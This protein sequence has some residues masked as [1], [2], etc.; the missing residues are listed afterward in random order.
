MPFSLRGLK[1]EQ[2]VLLTHG[3]SVDQVAKEFKIIAQSGKLIAGT[4]GHVNQANRRDYFV[5]KEPSLHSLGS[6][7]FLTVR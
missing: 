4:F 7:T 6:V 1:K 5:S 2:M 3:D